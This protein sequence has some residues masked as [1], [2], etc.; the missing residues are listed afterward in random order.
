MKTARLANGFLYVKVSTYLRS[1][2]HASNLD[3]SLLD[4][5]LLTKPTI[6]QALQYG[7]ELLRPVQVAAALE[8]EIL[9]GHC[10]R[11]NRAYL[12]TWPEKHLSEFVYSQ[13]QQ[14]ILR[15]QQGEPIA[16]LT[17]YKEFWDLHLRV[18]PAVLIPRPETEHLVELALARIPAEVQWQ[19]ADLGTGSGA[20]ALAIAKERPRCQITAIDISTDALEIAQENAAQNQI[21]NIEFRLSRWFEALAEERFHIIVANPPYIAENDPHL[22]QGDLR[23][24]PTQ[25][26]SAKAGGLNELQH[27]IYHA[28]RYLTEPGWLLLE[29]GYQQGDTV[30]AMLTERGFYEVQ[31]HADYAHLERVSIGQFRQANAGV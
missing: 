23:F 19:I 28:P 10:L 9:L 31:C 15:R 17:G 30:T 21:H 16:Y 29:H 4:D 11:K 8:A 6:A 12:R 27:I 18:T 2:R 25:A 7:T 22:Q 14:L 3:K 13:Y 5:F 1:L 26:L 20:V 24:E